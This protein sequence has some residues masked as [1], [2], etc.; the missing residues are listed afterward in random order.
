MTIKN[1]ITGLLLM[2]FVF[3]TI[4]TQAQQIE[5]VYFK[6]FKMEAYENV[7]SERILIKAIETDNNYISI[8]EDSIFI[9]SFIQGLP[10]ELKVINT[11]FNEENQYLQSYCLWGEKKA[12]VFITN[13]EVIIFKIGTRSVV[14]YVKR[15]YAAN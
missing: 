15:L 1:F 12:S 14:Y 10:I 9:D 7:N 3:L 13:F 5:P 8:K 6:V 4:T 2:L 11:V